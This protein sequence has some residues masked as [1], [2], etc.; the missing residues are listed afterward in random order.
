MI[1]KPPGPR[2]HF[3]PDLA[4]RLVGKG[5]SRTV[6]EAT[7]AIKAVVFD[8]GGVLEITPKTGWDAQWEARLGLATGVLNEKLRD[9]WQGG[10]IGTLSEAEVEARVAA[11]LGLDAAQ[12]AA[13]MAGLW[14]EYLGT[15]NGDLAAYFGSL[16]PR[17]KTGILSNSFVGARER[18]HAQYG[19]GE[20]C[21]CIVYSHESGM[22][23]P[24]RAFYELVCTRLGVLP[25][26]TIFLDDVAEAVAA[27][28]EIGIH[29]IQFENNAQAI[30]AIE[31]CLAA[32]EARD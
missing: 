20:L 24:Q 25:H 4:A 6:A 14:A 5:R 1:I 10:S 22:R 2:H 27:A 11:E 32:E 9:A 18:E 7:M 19:F 16:R 28:R 31:A 21:D 3:A 30:G 8:I 15:L 26:E 13:F 29:G 17:Y 23:K 12:L